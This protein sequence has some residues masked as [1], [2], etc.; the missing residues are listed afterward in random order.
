ML[1]N[2]SHVHDIIDRIRNNTENDNNFIDDVI[3]DVCDIFLSCAKKS[4]GVKQKY[5]GLANKGNFRFKKPWFTRDC[6]SARQNFRKA[7][8]LY[9]K[10]GGCIFKD[11]LYTKERLYKK[12]LNNAVKSHRSEI[13]RK[14]NVLRSKNPKEY[15]KVINS[16]CRKPQKCSV[17]IDELFLLQ[18]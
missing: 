13:K 14:L 11:D 3:D 5:G 9:K 7:K 2:E 6:K 8:R 15:W 18:Q 12:T 16:N 1:E 4:F 10:F 17:G